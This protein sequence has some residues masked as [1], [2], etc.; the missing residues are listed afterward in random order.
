MVSLISKIQIVAISSINLLSN[1]C[2]I[3]IFCFDFKVESVAPLTKTTAAS[4]N[5]AHVG[6]MKSKDKTII[7]SNDND[8][9]DEASPSPRY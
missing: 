3:H 6:I 8:D 4:D 9:D 2:L 5:N 7:D 1:I